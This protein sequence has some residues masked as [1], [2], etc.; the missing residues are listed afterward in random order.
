MVST[1]T[2]RLECAEA[3]RALIEEL[4]SI[5][6]S[7][8]TRVI[9]TIRAFSSV[10]ILIKAIL[11][12]VF[13]NLTSY[14]RSVAHSLSRHNPTLYIEQ[15]TLSVAQAKPAHSIPPHRKLQAAIPAVAINP[16]RLSVAPTLDSSLSGRPG[17]L[18]SRELTRCRQSTS[19]PRPTR[20]SMRLRIL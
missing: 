5:G 1:K 14:Q 4:D 15:A 2:S 8:D 16:S 11:G 3:R 9:T 20:S 7:G 19:C 10:R 18:L 12:L 13:E 6:S 17:K